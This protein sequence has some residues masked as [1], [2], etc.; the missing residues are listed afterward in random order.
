MDQYQVRKKRDV[1]GQTQAA[2]KKEEQ[3]KSTN[4]HQH[5]LLPSSIHRLKGHHLLQLQL[6]L[7]TMIE[8]R[9]MPQKQ[10]HE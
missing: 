4:L 8:S 10:S 1:R 6:A 9:L 5:Y 3:T 7:F 2:E